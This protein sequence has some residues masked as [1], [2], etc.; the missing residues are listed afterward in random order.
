MAVL[1]KGGE[2]YGLDRAEGRH[3]MGMDGCCG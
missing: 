3:E 2:G 1:L